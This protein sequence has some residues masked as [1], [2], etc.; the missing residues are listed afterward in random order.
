MCVVIA[1]VY[2]SFIASNAYAAWESTGAGKLW[3]S[4]TKSAAHLY[5]LNCCGL[6]PPKNQKP[7]SVKLLLPNYFLWPLAPI[8]QNSF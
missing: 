2:W 7:T 6:R 5:F 4:V 3:P 8:D 1:N